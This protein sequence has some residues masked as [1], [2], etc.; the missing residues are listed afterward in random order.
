MTSLDSADEK[1]PSS[2]TVPA[3]DSLFKKS[4]F[5]AHS[6]SWFQFLNT[7]HSTKTHPPSVYTIADDTAE[8]CNCSALWLTA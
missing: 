5:P 1:N 4:Q 6:G 3:T 7:A 2:T 8:S